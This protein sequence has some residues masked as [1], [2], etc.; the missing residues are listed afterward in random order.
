MF[1]KH[2]LKAVFYNIADFERTRHK[3]RT[4]QGSFLLGKKLFIA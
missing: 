2:V 4:M 3:K 1:N